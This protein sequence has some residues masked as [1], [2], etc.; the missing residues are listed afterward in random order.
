MPTI[1]FDGIAANFKPVL[2][3]NKSKTR[4]IVILMIGD[5]VL[6]QE[7]DFLTL[8]HIKYLSYKEYDLYM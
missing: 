6:F 8:M 5:A 7:R 2:V 3:L 1:F 4:G